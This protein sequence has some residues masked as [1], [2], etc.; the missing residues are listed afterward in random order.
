VP[1]ER[2]V[3]IGL[4]RPRTERPASGV[5][6]SVDSRPVPPTRFPVFFLVFLLP[7]F[8]FLTSRAGRAAGL[9]RALPFEL[10][11]AAVFRPV[12]RPAAVVRRA[13]CD[14]GQLP[15]RRPQPYVSRE[16][17]SG[18]SLSSPVSGPLRF[19]LTER[20]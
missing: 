12:L 19:S 4:V 7:A 1:V 15:E 18:L 10:F 2:L 17:S 3:G 16:W 13:L 9:R 6:A 11:A 5:C 20:L 8:A 14:L